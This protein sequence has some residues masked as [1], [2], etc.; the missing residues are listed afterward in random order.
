MA[1]L[2]LTLAALTLGFP[3]A[4]VSLAQTQMA[5]ANTPAPSTPALSIPGETQCRVTGNIYWNA[6]IKQYIAPDGYICHTCTPENGFPNP[7]ATTKEG[8]FYLPDLDD[9]NT[10]DGNWYD[11]DGELCATCTPENGFP[12]P[13]T[14]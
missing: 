9:S 14:P 3:L 12:V 4:S 6:D 5:G 7:P 10:I 8:F 13:P 2:S 11:P 1:R